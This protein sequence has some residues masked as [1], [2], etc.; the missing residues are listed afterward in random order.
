[1]AVKFWWIPREWNA[2]ADG[3]AKLAAAKEHTPT[4]WR[5]VMGI[6]INS[7]FY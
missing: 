4:A 1:M 3:F 5:E 7:M 2:V 6:G